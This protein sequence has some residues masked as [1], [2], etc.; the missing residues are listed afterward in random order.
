MCAILIITTWLYC[1]FIGIRVSS[2]GGCSDRYN[3]RCTSLDSIRENT[4]NGIITFKNANGCPVTITG[5]TEVHTF[6]YCNLII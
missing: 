6:Y 4:I 5:G 1:K 2:S 3:S